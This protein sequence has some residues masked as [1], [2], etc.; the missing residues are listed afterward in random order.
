MFTSDMENKVW[1]TLK[2]K[3]GEQLGD[4]LDTC[5]LGRNENRN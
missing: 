5:V 3:E 4:E 1:R 2:F